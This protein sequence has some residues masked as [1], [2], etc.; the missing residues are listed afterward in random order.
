MSQDGSYWR[1]TLEKRLSRRQALSLAATAGA[2]T[3]GLAL[4]GCGGDG[5]EGGGGGS[6]PAEIK[7]QRAVDVLKD[8]TKD[9]IPGGVLRDSTTSNVTGTLDPMISTSFTTQTMAATAY[10]VLLRSKSRPERK[11]WNKAELGP[12]LVESWEMSE[13]GTTFTF[14]MRPNVRFHNVPPVNGRVMD[15][16]DWRLSLERF[17]AVSPYKANLAEPLDKATFPDSR[18]MVM[19]MKYSYGPLLWLLTSGSATFWVMPKEAFGGG[20]DP[21]T[22]VIGTY[23]TVLDKYQPDVVYEYKRHDNYWRQKPWIE[24]WRYF[25]IPEREQRRAQF[26]VKTLNTY[27]PQQADVLQ[28]QKD[29]PDAT[30]WIA[31]ATSGFSRVYFGL[32]EFETSPWKDERVRQALSMA[33][34]WPALRANFSNSKE[35]AAAGLP[36]EDLRQSFVRI[37]WRDNGYWLDPAKKELGDASKYL[38][39]NLPEA[40]KLLE[41][42]GYKSAVEVPEAFSSLGVQ[43][44]NDYPAHIGIL[45]DLL[46]Q[47]GLFK[48]A[49]RTA[50]PYADFLQNIYYDQNFKGIAMGPELT[51]SE[52]DSEMYQ[53]FHSKGARFKAGGIKDPKVDEF[54]ERQRSELDQSKRLNILH[55]FQKYMATKM[56]SVPYDGGS[57]SFSFSWGQVRNTLWPG[58]NQFLSADYPNRNG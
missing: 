51:F 29:V 31:D 32:K 18:T 22:Q 34:D 16:E 4:L 23:Y 33:V 13:D 24:R 11:D 28:L 50:L 9:A 20:M 40:K 30:I 26:V 43:Y 5:G 49:K 10:E 8:E 54:V 37:A 57:S 58:W 7:I 25:I 55:D 19:K 56:Y 21:A 15:I 52:V 41:A 17:L 48:I 1:R 38:L 44:G 39:Y 47:S 45:W 35:F 14:R 6:K 53:W 46:D 27:A 2:G 42:A 12:R 36:T 3:A